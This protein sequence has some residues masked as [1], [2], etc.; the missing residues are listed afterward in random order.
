[1]P[2]STYAI[3]FNNTPENV[4]SIILQWLQINKFTYKQDENGIYWEYYDTITG[5]RGLEYYIQPNQVIF[6]AWIN[7][8][9]KPYDLEGF[10]GALPKQAFLTDL[11]KLFTMIQGNKESMQFQNQQYPYTQQ[12]TQPQNYEN[13]MYQNYSQP[14][15][16]PNYQQPMQNGMQQIA[17]EVEK[18]S[19]TNAILSLILGICSL[20]SSCLAFT[21]VGALGAI[22]PI[23]GICCGVNSNKIKK[24]G[25]ATTGIILNIISLV[26]IC[27]IFIFAIIGIFLQ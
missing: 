22:F 4:N 7:K 24:S 3:P 25:M 20:L 27:I 9:N 23:I 19:K 1:M 18:K 14:N 17:Q 5:Y 2:K 26:L 8:R 6:N 12:Q 10:V 21:G 11:Q 16:Q 15:L 13:S